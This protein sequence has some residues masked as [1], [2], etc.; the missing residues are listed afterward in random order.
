MANTIQVDI[1]SR[2]WLALSANKRGTQLI[3]ALMDILGLFRIR[4]LHV[5]MGEFS[6]LGN[7]PL[8]LF[9]YVS[10][11]LFISLVFKK[12]TCLELE[13]LGFIMSTLSKEIMLSNE[14]IKAC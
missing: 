6:N 14:K 9:D 5:S 4:E 3:G 2:S 11:Y 10:F 1:F 12:K 13:A 7:Y 8:V